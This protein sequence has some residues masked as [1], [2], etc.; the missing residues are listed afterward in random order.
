ML[1]ISER[2]RPCSARI[3]PS[4]LG[5]VTVMA[6]STLATSMGGETCSDRTPLGPFTVTSRPSIVTS[7]PPGITTGIRP[8][9]DICVSLPDVGEDFPAYS[10]LVRLLVRHQAAG[11]GDDRHAEPAEHPRQ[12]V[13]PR[14]QDRKST[15]LNSSHV[16]SSYAVFCL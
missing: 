16:K 15:R 2:E 9:R 8:I 5:L 13:L 1:A 7:T 10:P 14:V 6:P 12:V 11:G 3:S 4:S